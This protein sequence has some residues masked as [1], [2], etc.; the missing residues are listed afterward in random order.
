MDVDTVDK[1]LQREICDPTCPRELTDD[2]VQMQSIYIS[3][4][5]LS[6]DDDEDDDV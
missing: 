2:P 4:P 3:R 1:C 6:C 5:R